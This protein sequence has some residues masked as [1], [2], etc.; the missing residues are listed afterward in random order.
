MIDA[1][2]RL[3]KALK[4]HIAKLQVYWPRR[5]KMGFYP[6]LHFRLLFQLR[7]G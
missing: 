3:E 1:M 7:D 4:P 6:R 2:I 5:L